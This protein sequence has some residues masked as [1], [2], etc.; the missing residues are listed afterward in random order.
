MPSFPSAYVWRCAY[1]YVGILPPEVWGHR[2]T[3]RRSVGRF[4][5]WRAAP[6]KHSI[7]YR[8]SHECCTDC[9][10]RLNMSSDCR[11]KNIQKYISIYSKIFQIA[12]VA[13]LISFHVWNYVQYSNKPITISEIDNFLCNCLCYK[14]PEKLRKLSAINYFGFTLLTK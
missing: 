2:L 10:S 8:V 3:L 6:F 11:L 14:L 13:F 9:F 4:Q 7:I 12:L 1:V 5:L